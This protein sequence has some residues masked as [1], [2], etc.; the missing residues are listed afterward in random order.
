MSFRLGLAG[1]SCLTGLGELNR[2]LA[3]YLPVAY[4]VVARNH[5]RGV[6]EP[7][8][9]PFDIEGGSADC[10]QKLPQE[11]DR[12]LFCERPVPSWLPTICAAH[13]IPLFCVPM[14]E[15]L[16]EDAS[17]WGV[18]MFI[19]PTQHCHDLLRNQ[20]R[21]YP[22]PWPVDTERFQFKKR[23]V[24]QR[25][26]FINGNGG[27]KGRKGGAVVRRLRELWRD[28]PIV[29]YSQK[30]L[31]W[32]STSAPADN[33]DLY[34][35][36]DVLIAPHSVDGIGLELLEA[37]AS[38]MPVISTDGRPWNE[39]PALARIKAGLTKNHTVKP[40]DWYQ[41]DAEHLHQ[42]CRE[43]LGKDISDHSV[44]ARQWA[45]ERSWKVCKDTFLGILGA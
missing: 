21:A 40:V 8:S 35:A 1:Y 29:I 11:V 9:V 20:L 4:W 38:G 26:V 41:P 12:L 6:V 15:W 43:W 37:A 5:L 25:F 30:R 28:I 44:A 34:K 22:F 3:H 23:D 45:E 24:C 27:Y 10:R 31:D 36:G 42:L 13:H 19:C 14:Q 16:P 39:F 7:A 18:R 32:A 2:Q 17:R 33:A